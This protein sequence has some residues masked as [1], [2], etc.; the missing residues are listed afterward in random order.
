[1]KSKFFFIEN[2]SIGF[3][4]N[5]RCGSKSIHKYFKTSNLP[6]K[7]SKSDIEIKESK[8]SNF[9]CVLR[10]PCSR[11]TSGIGQMLGNYKQIHG[12]FEHWTDEFLNKFI[13]DGRVN[14][15]Q[16]I[17]GGM[18]GPGYSWIYTHT[19]R[20]YNYGRNCFLLQNLL[21]FNF[22][23]VILDD[24]WKIDNRFKKIKQNSGN[25]SFDLF[26]E[27]LNNFDSDHEFLHFLRYIKDNLRTNETV[28]F[29]TL[30][31]LAN[32]F[33]IFFNGYMLDLLNHEQNT[34]LNFLETR[35]NEI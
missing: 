10:N 25:E 2:D 5:E 27:R 17:K 20:F 19:A 35:Y 7:T 13:T 6:F 32:K 14:H 12:N 22:K 9:Y 8:Y 1:M 15:Q 4:T 11:W 28:D 16:N 26:V 30:E 18:V 31:Y 29:K 24:L 33:P 21:E 23:F 34:Y 3:I